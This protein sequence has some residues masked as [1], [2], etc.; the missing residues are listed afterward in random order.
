MP[1]ALSVG[2]VVLVLLAACGGQTQSELPSQT[3][4]PEAASSGFAPDF[5]ITAYRGE[6]VLG[7]EETPFSKLLFRGKPVVLN[8][9][10]GACPPCRAEMPE[11]E[12]VHQQYKDRVVLLGLD[13]GPFVG[14]GSR[15]DGK[16]LIAELGI[17][18]PTGTTF[19]AEVV[20][21]YG[22]LGMPTT[23]FVKPNGKI[24]RKWTGLLNKTK[25]TELVEE[26]L[27]ASGKP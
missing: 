3:V 1:V 22:V 24:I 2:V 16:K 10:A 15:E 12:Q 11:F 17:T 27:A 14:L 5:R 4:A 20:K 9:W 23:I 21:E 26:L 8:F 18:Y 7:G 13:V 6:D 25:M 19:D